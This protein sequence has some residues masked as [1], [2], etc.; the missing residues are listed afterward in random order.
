MQ[1]QRELELNAPIPPIVA[2]KFISKT[3]RKNNPF[4]GIFT[5]PKRVGFCSKFHTNEYENVFVQ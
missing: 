3:K 5:T 4:A 1:S 2:L